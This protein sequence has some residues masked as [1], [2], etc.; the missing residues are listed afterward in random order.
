MRRVT[1][2]VLVALLAVAFGVLPSLAATRTVKIKDDFYSP[3][4]LTVTRGTT[5]TWKWVGSNDHNV[6]LK[7]A[8]SGVRH[9]HSATKSSGT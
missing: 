4:R 5:I 3:N 1:V 8:P 2:G 9:T 6:T 7:R